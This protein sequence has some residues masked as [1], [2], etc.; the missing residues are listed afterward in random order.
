[1]TAVIVLG[2]LAAAVIVAVLVA[3][4]HL[5]LEEQLDQYD[6]EA[7]EAGPDVPHRDRLDP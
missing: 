6:R 7:T 4:H 3:A 5:D 1:M 2:A